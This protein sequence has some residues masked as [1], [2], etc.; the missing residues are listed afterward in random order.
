MYEKNIVMY[1]E[2]IVIHP[3]CHISIIHPT[4]Y[5]CEIKIEG[6][7]EAGKLVI[8]MFRFEVSET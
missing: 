2:N 4:N 5:V 8:K 6:I 7:W 3:N 1:E